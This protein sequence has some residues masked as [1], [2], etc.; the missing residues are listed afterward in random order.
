M[1]PV[2][3]CI[4]AVE[5]EQITELHVGAPLQV[6]ALYLGRVDPKGQIIGAEALRMQP[7]EAEAAGTFRFTSPP[8]VCR[9]SGLHGYTVRVLP[10]HPA[11]PASFISGLIIWA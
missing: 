8:V 6:Q 9:K 7:V 5:S 1:K 2:Q 10:L 11:L 3:V 4:E